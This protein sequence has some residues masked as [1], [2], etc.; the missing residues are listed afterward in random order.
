MLIQGTRP[1]KAK[2]FS[3]LPASCITNLSEFI[4]FSSCSLTRHNKQAFG[5]RFCQ[6]VSA[7]PLIIL[8]KIISRTSLPVENEMAIPNIILEILFIEVIRFTRYKII[9][10]QI[11]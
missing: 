3:Y 9:P 2:S 11:S 1:S 5:E 8:D 7:K 4:V 10:L 6:T